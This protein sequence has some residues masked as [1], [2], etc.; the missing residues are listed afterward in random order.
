MEKDSRFGCMKP[1]AV[2]ILIEI[3]IVLIFAF[4]CTGDKDKN[5][6][7]G[8][9]IPPQVDSIECVSDINFFVLDSKINTLN[10]ELTSARDSIQI[11]KDSLS[12]YSDS[13]VFYKHNFIDAEEALFVAEYKLGRIKEYNRIAAQGNNIKYLR[14]WLNRVLNEN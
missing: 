6:D 11:Y 2:I 8:Y 5:P 12:I 14:G 3:I 13:I 7:T 10:K 1:A 4:T 9:L